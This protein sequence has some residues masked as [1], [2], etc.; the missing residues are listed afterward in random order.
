MYESLASELKAKLSDPKAAPILLPP[1]DY[2]TLSRRQGKLTGIELRR[3]TN[4]Q[5]VGPANA[6]GRCSFK[7]HEEEDHQEHT[8]TQTAP[9][10]T[11]DVDQ[12]QRRSQEETSNNKQE[13]QRSRSNS[14]SGL[15]SI[16][17]AGSSS[18]NETI[19]SGASRSPSSSSS[20]CS[21]GD[22]S[23]SCEAIDSRAV[24]EQHLSRGK[25]IENHNPSKV[26]DGILWNGRVEI[27]L[28]VNQSQKNGNTYLATKQIIY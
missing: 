25:G 11:Q 27:P 17:L 10:W 14:S 26:S 16:S 13:P 8:W 9:T 24:V 21:H 3:S 20:S 22:G 2:D 18:P 7:L 23:G 28:K 1:K 6:L 19:N 4:P 15:G 5:L 12:E